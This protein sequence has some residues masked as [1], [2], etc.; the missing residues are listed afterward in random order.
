MDFKD[1]GG[2][3]PGHNMWGYDQ[4]KEY[5]YYINEINFNKESFFN[6]LGKKIKILNL[7]QQLNLLR[8]SN[9]YNIIYSPFIEDVF[10]LALLKTLGLYNKPIIG[11]GIDDH[12]PY[13]KNIFKKLRQKIVRY[14]YIHGIDNLLYIT[15]KTYLKSNEYSKL[16]NGHS[17]SRS[18]G[19]DL[20]FI[21][22]FIDKQTEPP[23]LDYI[24][25]TGGSGR[26]YKTLIEAFAEINF[27][28]RITTKRD[29][30]QSITKQLTPNISINNTIKPGLD[31]VSIMRKEY[32]DAL[33]VA[34]PLNGAIQNAPIGLT[35]IWEALAMGKPIICTKNQLHQFDYEKEKV[36]FIINDKDIEGW[37]QCIKYLIN[38]P[39]EAKEMGARGRYLCEKKYNYKLFSKEII[40][41]VNYWNHQH[42]IEYKTLKRKFKQPTL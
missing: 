4:I 24:Y 25:S 8:D 19:A 16:K 38:N 12:T 27:N 14:I 9:N 41:R 28:L 13:K 5:G 33:A 30:E 36:G 35:V 21:N 42:D 37:K 1:Q 17:F 6:K 34:I 3:Y 39:D 20:D 26:D 32:Y 22:S 2:E 40:E 23:T 10:L 15:E 31:S 7:Q 18:W 11:M 29:M